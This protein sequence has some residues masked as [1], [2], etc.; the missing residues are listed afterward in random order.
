MR[1]FEI[2]A[3]DKLQKVLYEY[4]VHHS[5][6]SHSNWEVM[7]N[8]KL[9]SSFAAIRRHY[10]AKHLPKFVVFGTRKNCTNLM[11]AIIPSSGVEVL[12]YIKYN[13]IEK[14]MVNASE[15]FKNKEINGIV[16]LDCPKKSDIKQYLL[17]QGMRMNKNLF[18]L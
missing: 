17:K 11:N 13:K 18:L 5:S 1:M 4:R 6:L 10:A 9:R 3:I 7:L 2:G 14:K 15:M 16:V 12:R 8:E